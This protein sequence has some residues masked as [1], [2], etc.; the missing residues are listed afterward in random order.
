MVISLCPIAT[1]ADDN[2]KLAQEAVYYVQ[3]GA[4]GNGLTEATP[5]SF[6]TVVADINT[7]YDADDTV[8]IKIVKAANEADSYTDI[9]QIGLASIEDI[10]AHSAMLVLTSANENDQSWLTHKNNY[11]MNASDNNNG[12]VELNGPITLTKL[13]LLDPRNNWHSDF[14]ALGHSVKFCSDISWYSPKISGDTINLKGEK[15]QTNIHGGARS[16]KTFTTAGVIEVCDGV[17]LGNG[18]G[19]ALSGYNTSG[20]M[21]FNE[22]ITFKI[23]KGTL[24]LIKLDNM[25][26]AYAHFKKNANLVFNGTTVNKIQITNTTSKGTTVDGAVQIISNGANIKAY[27][28]NEALADRTYY[29][30]SPDGIKL[31]VTETAGKYTVDSDNIVYIISSDKKTVWYSNN[32]YINVGKAGTYNAISAATAEEMITVVAATTGISPDKWEDNGTGI[33]NASEENNE[34]GAVFYVQHGASGNGLTEATPGSFEYVVQTI[35]KV[36]GKGDTVTIKVV[37][38]PNEADSYTD[39]STIGL[40]CWNDIPAHEAMLVITSAD[41]NNQSWITNRNQYATSGYISTNIEI[42]G[43]LTLKDIKIVD[44]RMD[45]YGDIYA[46]AHDFII[47]EG[48][49]WYRPIYSGGTLK[50]TGY[51]SQSSVNGGSRSTKTFYTEA[52]IELGD[53]VCYGNTNGNS[54]SGYNTSGTMTFNESITYKVGKGTMQKLYIDNMNGGN[55]HYKK[56]VNVV[57]N[58][59]TVVDFLSTRAESKGTVVDGYIQIIKNGADVKSQ[60]IASYLMDKVYDITS[61]EGAKLDVTE[62]AGKY[63]V[64]SDNIVYIQSA[65]KK[66]AWYS[67]DGYITID[68][69]GTYNAMSASSVDEIKNALDI[70]EFSSVYVFGGWEDNGNGKIVA[71]VTENEALKYYIAEGASGSGA[72]ESDPCSMKQAMDALGDNDG[73]I[74]VI[75]TYTI[76]GSDFASH[77]GH[78]VIEGADDSAIIASKN[79]DGISFGGPV[80]FKNIT[81]KRGTNSYLVTRGGDVVFDKGF[82]TTSSDD[83]MVFG[84][85]MGSTSVSDINVTVNE[86]NLTGKFNVGA[87]MPS[88]SGFAV[89]N[90]ANINVNGGSISNLL[91]GS[92]NW[93]SCG[94]VTFEKSVVVINN[95]GN[96]S[97]I[98]AVA[99]GSG[100][101]TKINGSL[102]V[103]SNNGAQQ[104]AFD[105]SLDSISIGAKYYISSNVGGNIVPMTD[106]N[107]NFNGKFYLTIDKDE[108][109]SAL[110]ENGDSLTT[111]EESGEIT[112][113]PGTTTVSYGD[114]PP[115]PGKTI[116]M[117]W[118]EMDKGYITLIFDDVRADFKTIFEIV[119]KEYNLPLCAAVPSNNIKNDPAT[120][121]ELQ[122]RG[123]E[124]LSHTKSHMVIK[125]FQTSWADVET[126]LGDSY[127]I[128]TEEGFN[129]N[130]IILAGGTGQIGV[131]DTE[132]RALIELITNKY[133]KY[134]DKYGLSTQYWKQRNWFSDR[135]LDQLKSIVDTHAANKTWEVIYGH[136][137]TEVSEENLRAFCEYLVQLQNEGK[138]KVVTY[139]YMHE[140]FG[141]WETPVDFGDTTYTVEFYGT[142]HEIGRAH[143]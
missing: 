44:P 89:K 28:P 12:N 48:V 18:N 131:S 92:T 90:D 72:S 63:T 42:S 116:P 11:S 67:K 83:W 111:I 124:I 4:S 127:R 37:K 110:V 51:N 45:Y 68:E 30:T 136:D 29:I 56:N 126:Q 81:Y 38:A 120:L 59:T 24:Q 10:P 87:I 107:G 50:L 123:G 112:L 100:S 130:G 105:A 39:L 132:Y 9:S 31:D 35:N 25:N 129:V 76:S 102:V 80:T 8:T 34:S 141:D 97:K 62:T 121:H 60:N 99:S 98:S 103:V 78:I 27:E 101:P 19:F 84:G 54:I 17:Q 23:G 109:H 138:I 85:A 74:F 26:G 114:Y 108:K 64:D 41:K 128:L 61:P 46:N 15:T 73:F 70:P 58:G 134:S 142:D 47:C 66:T 93:G 79:G 1:F 122:D 143:V 82:A 95:G 113:N 16:T 2:A 7:K 140:N 65:D 135:T 91:L 119:S 71:K 40:A 133:Y 75:G 118:K 49:K 3:H 117:T 77:A 13:K 20:T 36:Y 86:G 125:P 5:G 14:Y 33:L 21:T 94:A 22:D 53:G 43:P 55:T 69:V 96:I 6:A 32:G 57:F 139:K 106:E 137:L 52:V 115:N 88:S 104:P